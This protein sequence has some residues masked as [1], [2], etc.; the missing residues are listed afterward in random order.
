M[1]FIDGDVDEIAWFGVEV[2]SGPGWAG[3]FK[4]KRA[5]A[6][7]SPFFKSLYRSFFILLYGPL[8]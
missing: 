4:F 7:Q 1:L 5:G 3:H 2:F 8:S 6:G